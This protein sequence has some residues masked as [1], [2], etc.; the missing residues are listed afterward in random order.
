MGNLSGDYM[1]LKENPSCSFNKECKLPKLEKESFCDEMSS[2]IG[3]VRIGKGVYVAPFVSLRADEGT[4]IVIGDETNLQDGVI[5][6]ALEHTS[7]E[8][9]KKTSIAHGAVI[10]G[11]MKIGDNSFIGFRAIV[12]SSEIGKECFIGHGAIVVG[13]KIADKKFVPHGAVITDQ[14]KANNLP[15]ASDDLFKFNE[16]VLEVNGEFARR[17]RK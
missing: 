6:H 2:I 4:P 16:G 10:H 17:Y 5:V 9:G 3:D 1:V 12:H 15:K 14:E 7:V 8:I 11:P 13:V